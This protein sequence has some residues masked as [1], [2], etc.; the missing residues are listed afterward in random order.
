MAGLYGYFPAM[1]SGLLLT[2]SFPTV[3]L[4]W[5]G[6]IA[7]APLIVSLDTLTARQGF[8]AGFT[9]GFIHFITL[10]YWIVP[11]L[12]TFGGLHPILAAAALIL[13]CLYLSVYPALFAFGLIKLGPSPVLMPLAA[14]CL[15]T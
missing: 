11:T 14:A 8:V 6:F 10:I 2:L 1:V 9:A 5:L 7:L 4:H 13:L 15:W 3:H 12:C